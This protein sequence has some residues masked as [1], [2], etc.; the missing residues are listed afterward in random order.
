VAAVLAEL[1][2]AP[3]T[4]HQV[5]ELTEGDTPVADAVSAAARA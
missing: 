4:A 5:L 3:G 1:L 2:H